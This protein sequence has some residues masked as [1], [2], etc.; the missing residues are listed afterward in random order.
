MSQ[1]GDLEQ[2]LGFSWR[3]LQDEWAEAR[4]EW[5]DAVAEKFELEYWDELEHEMPQLLGAISEFDEEFRQAA[6]SLED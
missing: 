5:R 1:L 2:D 6:L 4:A 3:T